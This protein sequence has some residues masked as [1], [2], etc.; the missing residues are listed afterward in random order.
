MNKYIVK[1]PVAPIYLREEKESETADEVMHGMVVQSIGLPKSDGYIEVETNYG[2]KGYM[3]L[4]SIILGNA[5][6]IEAWEASNYFVIQEIADVM[7]KPKYASVV[8]I[9]LPRGAKVI[10][11]G[12]SEDDWEKVGLVDGSFGWIRSSFLKNI[13]KIEKSEEKELRESIAQ[14]ALQYI[15]CQ[16]RWGG[17]TPF[18]IDCSGLS[19]MAYMLNGWLIPR[20]ADVQENEFR[21]IGRNDAKKGDLLF[22]PGHVGIYLG[23]GEYVHASGRD[24]C[25]VI[26]SIKKGVYNYRE[27]HDREITSIGTIF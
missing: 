6:G 10:Y 17:K 25:V 13:V 11:T 7:S 12:V 20:D 2:Y 8:K 4:E 21:T 16:Y 23:E 5:R 27:D 26:N 1:N 15:G 22:F 9:T 18:G 3:N 19:S 24:G 14:T